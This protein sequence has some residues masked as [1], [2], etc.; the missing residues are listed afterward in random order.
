MKTFKFERL[1]TAAKAAMHPGRR[2]EIQFTGD[3]VSWKEALRASDGYDAGVILEKTRAAALKV[4]QGDR[5]SV[6][7]VDD[8]G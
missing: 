6:V 7:I 8:A 5:F 2:K 4:K 3:Y 1:W